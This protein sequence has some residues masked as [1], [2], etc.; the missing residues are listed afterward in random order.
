MRVGIV[1]S[2]MAGLAAG[3]ELRKAGHEVVVFEKSKGLGGRGATR[4]VGEYVFDTGATILSPAKSELERVMLEELPTEDLVRVDKPIFMHSF[5]R[6]TAIDP[7]RGQP[8]RY[9]YKRGMNTLGKLLAEGMDVRLETRIEGIESPA[10]G[11]FAMGGEAFD[12]VILTPPL[13]QTEELLEASG[14]RHRLS[15]SRYR[16][17][18]SVMLGFN[19]PLDK[20]YHALLDPDQSEP[21]TWLSLE[22][23][24]VPGGFRAPEGHTAIVAQMSARYS[25]YS[26]EKDD[27]KIIHDTVLD[28]SRIL[29]QQYSSPVVSDV[30]RWRYSHVSNVVG[31]DSVNVPG[32][33]LVIASDGLVGARMQQAYDMGVRAARQLI[34]ASE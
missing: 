16:M 13:P 18:L 12:A 25:R 15:N 17:C 8:V 31:F 9:A 29:G 24:K 7:Q 27:K 10:D 5:G 1:G 20:H 32:S 19:I 2:G 4:R 21:L 23:V 22:T 3:R 11:G 14:M 34:E 28:V 26:F 33:K 30:M 6:I